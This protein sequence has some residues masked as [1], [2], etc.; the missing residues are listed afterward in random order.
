MNVI[1]DEK[2]PECSCGNK[3][4]VVKFV[5]DYDDF[6]YFECSKCELDADDYKADKVQF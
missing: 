4:D 2:R 5:G 1:A 6:N 3:M